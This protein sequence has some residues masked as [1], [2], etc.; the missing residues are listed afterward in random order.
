MLNPEAQGDEKMAVQPKRLYEQAAEAIRRAEEPLPPVDPD[1]PDL[2]D[3]FDWG[4]AVARRGHITPEVSRRILAAVRRYVES[5]LI[6]TSSFGP[7]ST[8]TATPR[9]CSSW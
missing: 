6:P 4:E 5:S 1:S 9:R 8:V 7:Y 3:L 2:D